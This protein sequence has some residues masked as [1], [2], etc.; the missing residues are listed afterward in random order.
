VVPLRRPSPGYGGWE[1][2]G[3]LGTWVRQILRTPWWG[4]RGRVQERPHLNRDVRG[5][6][7]WRI[8]LDTTY[9]VRENV[10]RNGTRTQAVQRP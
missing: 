5:R 8:G 9:L 7:T 3:V 2:N 1:A 4:R 10:L 6:Q